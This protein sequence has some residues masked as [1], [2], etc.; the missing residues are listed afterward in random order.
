MGRTRLGSSLTAIPYLIDMPQRG[1]GPLGD[2][3]HLF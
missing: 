1:L 2:A 3:M